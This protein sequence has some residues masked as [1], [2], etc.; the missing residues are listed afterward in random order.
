MDKQLFYHRFTHF[1]PSIKWFSLIGFSFL[2]CSVISISRVY[3]QDT[4]LHPQTIQIY[5]TYQP[6]LKQAD[7]LSLTASLPEIDTTHPQLIYNIPA[8]NLHFSYRPVPLSPLAIGPD[9]VL[10]LQRYF[11]Q[12]AAGSYLTTRVRAGINSGRIDTTSYQTPFSYALLLD[13]LSSKGSLL[14]Q[15]FGYDAV[16][17]SG[18]Y[19][20]PHIAYTGDLR[21]QRDGLYYYGYNHDSLHFNK[22][23]IRQIFTQFALHA[24]M[25][26][27]HK[28][29]VGIDY[30]PQLSL[31][32]F[33]DHYQHRE[34]AFQIDVPIEKTIVDDISLSV[35]YTGSYA[36]YSDQ[37]TSA[38]VSNTISTIHP[39]LNIEKPGFVLHAG[40]NPSWTNSQFFLLPDIVNETSLIHEKLILSSGWISYFIQ[41]SFQHLSR[42]NPYFT[43][44]PIKPYNT[45]VEE[46]YTGFK[47]SLAGHFTYNT[48]FAYVTYHDLPLFLNDSLDGKTFYPI[49]ESK[50]EAYQ[51]HLEL[52]YLSEES[53]QAGFR[54]NWMNYF[55]QQ[56]AQ[57]P[58]GLVPFQADIFARITAWRALQL[59]ADLFA[60]SGSYY[61]AKD[62]S[63]HQTSGIFDMNLGAGYQIN[64]NFEVGLEVH[65]LFNSVYERWHQYPS[66]GMQVL[67]SI[68][69]KF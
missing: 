12:A 26:N 30:H 58:W 51:L 28:N 1:Q 52:N 54:L 15:Q 46:K 43:G 24:G 55:H 42:E 2:W 37:Q 39:A 3:A 23:D 47:G 63:A 18:R 4:T 6:V 19:F 53:F 10:P 7:K 29:A 5:S 31:S 45:R 41:N 33:A 38:S 59:N 34:S 69:L 36:T 25:S 65:N 60:W 27:I 32:I 50:L 61:R 11:V 56:T 9:T 35:A 66:L 48:K 67:G 16:E 8:L 44:Y 17:A 57:K 62:L 20:S 49:R 22:K 64:T 14:Y 21:F 68:S 13:H 40:L